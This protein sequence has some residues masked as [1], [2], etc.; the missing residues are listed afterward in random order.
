MLDSLNI[1]ILQNDISRVYIQISYMYVHRTLTQ[2]T[3]LMERSWL[4]KFM[5]IVT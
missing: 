2:D 4:L 3:Y 1:T 5:V